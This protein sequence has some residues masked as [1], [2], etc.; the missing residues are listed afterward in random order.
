MTMPYSTPAIRPD[1]GHY[2][3]RLEYYENAGEG[4][5]AGDPWI[6][7]IIADANSAI[8]EA[9]GANN[10]LAGFPWLT[11]V[12]GSGCREALAFDA[13]E[14][15]RQASDR[16]RQILAGEGMYGNLCLDGTPLPELAARFTESLI[17]DRLRGEPPSSPGRGT[18]T[19]SDVAPHI[20][21]LT[22]L[23]TRLYHSTKALSADAICRSR[24]DVATLP[25]SAGK[26]PEADEL[27]SLLMESVRQV[28]AHLENLLE[29]RPEPEPTLRLLSAITTGL[30]PQKDDK[31]TTLRI[32]ELIMMTELAWFYLT[33]DSR[34]YP[35]LS[36]ESI[37]RPGWTDLLLEL[38]RGEPRDRDRPKTRPTFNRFDSPGDP[39]Y[40]RYQQI[41]KASWARYK[42]DR[43]RP[44][45]LYTSVARVLTAQSQFHNE[46]IAGFG[47]PTA[48]VFVTTFDLELEMALWNEENP[49]VVAMP[50][51]VL[52]G[53]GTRQEKAHPI[54]VACLIEPG[55]SR[56]LEHHEQL[57]AL[58]TPT[59]WAVQQGDAGFCT[60]QDSPSGFGQ[61]PTVVRLTGC[62]LILLP[63]I[64]DENG[65]TPLGRAIVAV[66]N[67]NSEAVTQPLKH[68]V[69][70]D[71]HSALR[72]SVAPISRAAWDLPPQYTYPNKLNRDAPQRQEWSRFWMILGVQLGDAGIRHRLMAQ[73]PLP[74]TSLAKKTG[75]AVHRGITEVERDS[76]WWYGF[77]VVETDLRDFRKDL[78]HY[79]KH[80]NKNLHLGEKRPRL[81]RLGDRCD[82]T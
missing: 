62:P 39:I 25:P 45:S 5:Y 38:S 53:S 13:H 73:I 72:L 77:D 7:H 23:L 50:A 48:S 26:I 33:E 34:L 6:C 24:A 1:A 36:N 32:T 63:P 69:V 42:A 28:Q 51:L 82:I 29:G 56:W 58:Q 79:L 52:E 19:I 70:I 57:N 54:W 80:L 22:F 20:I 21:L 68:A 4:T 31:P 81:T 27:R 47:V 66:H 60:S 15:A 78:D 64:K 75:V 76:L 59:K 65:L 11:L 44:D 16:V 74:D 41:T 30:I 40:I 61:Y 2:H 14:F 10:K 12:L 9:H 37:F 18:F 46:Y 67:V 8:A 71:E 35:D 3:S 43:A 17:A 55:E 49:F